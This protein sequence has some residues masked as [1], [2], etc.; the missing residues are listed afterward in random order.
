MS[1]NT[2]EAI[3]KLVQDYMIN[4]EIRGPECSRLA[5]A[6]RRKDVHAINQGIRM[7]RKSGGELTDEKLF[8]TR[9]SMGRGRQHSIFE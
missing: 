4:L 8:K 9:C 3:A 1:A 5:L 2:S 7:A 6:Y